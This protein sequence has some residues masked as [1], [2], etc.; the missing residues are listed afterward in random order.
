MAEL[1]RTRP[2]GLNALY[3]AGILNVLADYI[4]RPTHFDLSHATCLMP[5]VSCRT[6]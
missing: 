6:L 3:I 4:S 1:L 5:L 2:L